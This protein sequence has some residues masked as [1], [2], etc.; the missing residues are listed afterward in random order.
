PDPADNLPADEIDPNRPAG[1][2]RKGKLL[3]LRRDAVV[4]DWCAK[5]GGPAGGRRRM[6]RLRWTPR[7]LQIGSS[8]LALA[9]TAVLVFE[10]IH[11]GSSGRLI[12]VSLLLLI[13]AI[14]AGIL[15]KRAEVELG[16]CQAARSRD[17]VFVTLDILS[18]IILGVGLFGV[19]QSYGPL[20]AEFFFVGMFLYIIVA[21]LVHFLRRPITAAR[22]TE[23]YVH[24]RNVHPDYLARL[25]EWPNE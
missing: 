21:R 14:T 6:L 11:N 7:W 4:P 25:P 16:C 22:I 19:Q 20:P 3:V 9:I 15:T 17:N 5:T 13:P 12:V 2:W 1:L 23:E 24:L 10:L 18:A 8:I